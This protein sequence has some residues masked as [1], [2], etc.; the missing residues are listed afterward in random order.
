MPFDGTEA[1]E[2][3]RA[4]TAARDKVAVAWCQ[5]EGRA[6]GGSVCAAAAL[7]ENVNLEPDD[8]ITNNIAWLAFVKAIGTRNIFKWNDTP[9]RTQAEVV[10]AFDRAIADLSGVAPKAV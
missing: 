3:I 1:S 4:L 6:P 9:G 2:A 8:M 10:A 5:N 7:V